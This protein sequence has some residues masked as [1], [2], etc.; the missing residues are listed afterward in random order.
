M[1]NE[2]GTTPY[3]VRV[4]GS[5]TSSQESAGA[6]TDPERWT[7][8]KAILDQALESPLERRKHLVEQLCAGDPG[9]RA[10]VNEYLTYTDRAEDLLGEEEL[11]DAVDET[12]SLETLPG[13]AGPYRI[14]REI[15]RGGMG[16]VCL[17]KRDDG[18]YERTVALKLIKSSGNRGKFARLFW[19]ERQILARLDHPNI[20]RLLDGGTTDS[21]QAYYAMEYVD[22][23]PLD[24][25][26]QRHELAVRDKLGLFISICSAVSYAHRNLI[27]HG[28][29]KPKN[30][31]V[32]QDGT[33][34]LLDFGVARILATGSQ[35]EATTRMP[36][37]P[38]YASPE[39]IRGE[40]LT[41]ATDVYSLGVL[42]YELLSG[43]YPYGGRQSSAAAMRAYL[44]QSP[45]PL[46]TQNSDIPADLENIVMMAL[47]KEPE[48]RYAT[49]DAFCRDIQAF[50]DGFPV[51][52]GP[53]TFLYRFGKFSRRNRWAMIAGSVA[54]AAVAV[55]GVM[56]WREKR[57]AEMRF[58]QLRQLAHSVVFELDD[59][60]LDLPGSSH[61]RELLISRGLQYLNGLARS[62][63]TDP[64]LTFE[65]AQAYMKIAGAQGDL[66]QAN[67]GDEAGAFASYTKARGMLVGLRSR[68]PDNRAVE[69]NLALVD[70]DIASLAPRTGNGDAGN[71]RRESVALFE[72]IARTET[73]SGNS[74]NLALAH[75]Y[76]AL[77]KTD[78]HQYRDALPLWQQSLSEYQLLSS[79]DKNPSEDQRNIG[80]VEKHIA[81]VYFAL[82]DY[83]RSLEYD[84]KAVATDE[85]RLR[86]SPQNPT[87]HMD[88]S[89][90]LVELG[91]CLHELQQNTEADVAFNRAIQLRRQVGGE[92]P[93]DFHA[94][95][96]L[97]SVL[98]IAGAA[99]S[100][101]GD[102]AGAVQL[103]QEAANT[104]SALH[105]HDPHNL[106]ETVSSALDYYEL[107]QVLRRRASEQAADPDDWRGALLSFERAQALVAQI[108]SATIYDASDRD[109]LSR[110]PERI[111]EASGHTRSHLLTEHQQKPLRA[112]GISLKRRRNQ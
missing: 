20:A 61:A 50:L 24:R 2:R 99:K 71:L 38:T 21:G 3:L 104:G 60:I 5:N 13:R 65:L 96:E 77:A 89:F 17:A 98:R 23:E 51:Q 58:Q 107:G 94:R 109:K 103:I 86:D 55:S 75:F 39:Q 57:Q 19:R 18:E 8:V 49:V 42:L 7:R 80:L 43:R 101:S 16:I 12:N 62:R 44:E 102:L 40:P 70:E 15:G 73:A 69:L 35:T 88:L 79:H 92:D 1:T 41:V 78:E 54:I 26:R 76:L 85:Q 81:S 22:G 36:L 63:N 9:L 25:Y 32:T 64:G 110:L 45:I 37:T 30:V 56:I 97:E 14:E 27:I 4:T 68:E 10:E 72:D 66:Q 47:R 31:L 53:D 48:R 112:A 74:K 84:R 11:P 100:E 87:A 59:A 91:W 90:D 28:D 52:A 108:P 6:R 67:V 95:S 111:A 105:A 33:P 82:A 29:L 34:K 46:R 83:Q 93:N 106:D